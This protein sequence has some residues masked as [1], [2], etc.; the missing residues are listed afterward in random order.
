[1]LKS[2]EFIENL[3]KELKIKKA[4]GE[5]NN[6]FIEMR[7][8]GL[9]NIYVV[10]DEINELKKLNL[11]SFEPDYFSDKKIKFHYLSIEDSKDDLFISK[12][13]GKS[14]FLGLRRSL[15][16]L[17]DLNEEEKLAS[18]RNLITFY[19]YKGGVG[20]TTSLALTASYLAKQ[21]KNV[22]VVD[23][24]FEAPGLLN[25]FN[26]SQSENNRSGL[27]E[28]LNDQTFSTKTELKDYVFGIESAYSGEG[29]INLISAG[30]ILFDFKNV[31]SYLEGIAKIDLQ[32]DSLQYILSKL[33]DDINNN[34]SPDVILVDSR[35]GFN[36]VF[37]ALASI[38]TH[39]VFLGGDDIQNQPGVEYTSNIINKNKISSSIILSIINSNFSKRFENFNKYISSLFEQEDKPDTFY[40]NRLDVLEKIGTESEDPSDLN[41]FLNGDI[42]PAQY[43]R[44]FKTIDDVV[45]SFKKGIESDFNITDGNET[46]L[47]IVSPTEVEVQTEAEVYS[48]I[49]SSPSQ[50]LIDDLKLQDLILEKVNSKLPNLYA[51]NIPYTPEY[52]ERDFYLRPCMEDFLIPEKNIL[53]GDKGTGKTAFYKA[54]Q[55]KSFFENLITKSQKKH[56]NYDVINIT[57]F[58]KDNFEFLFTQDEFKDEIFVKKFWLFFIWNSLFTRGGFKTENNNLL[59]SLEAPTA[60]GKIFNIIKN[61]SNIELIENDLNQANVILRKGDRRLIITFDQLDNIVKPVIWDFVI[62]PLVK[63]AVRF[64]YSNINPKLFLRRDLYDRL[65]NLTN[66]N[67]FS[68]KTINLEWSQDE[69]F[70]FFL[71]IV[72]NYARNEFLAFLGEDRISPY[73]LELITKKLT[74]KS[75]L[76]NQLPLDSGVIEPV[77]NSFFGY[78][79]PKNNGT[80]STAYIDLYRNIQSA[81]KTVNLRPFIDLLINAIDEQKE[82]DQNKGFR[83]DAIIGLAYCTSKSVRK[84]AVLNYLG[85]LW[86]EQGNEFIKYFCADFSQ[87]KISPMF[88]RNW[89]DESSFDKLI[90]EIKENNK[91]D[92]SI[93]GST[94]EQLK[95]VL[96]ATKIITTYMVGNKNRYSI[97]YL[98]TNY[99]GL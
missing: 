7:V 25:F 18:K 21:G 66:K 56:L 35:T 5:I 86:N 64:P 81:D 32:G 72:F 67:A 19:S 93:S 89:L 4:K 70:S 6:F 94:V 34:Y 1:M 2:I 46:P 49:H 40:F 24:D 88:K 84:N 30:N 37:G 62:S 92:E 60:I 79:R 87:N 51:E 53:L 69:I 38:S 41:D 48:P 65:G 13:E 73:L 31:V 68:N 77:I 61:D 74:V 43:H 11:S 16:S 28:Y 23:C 36:N 90:L 14:Y 33:I 95:Q 17:L 27:V 71:K 59:V 99:L 85:D 47:S 29:S 97:A 10:S 83:K 44:F 9:I 54:L 80:M 50:I 52:M 42:G 75:K 82:Q 12:F 57:N 20:R 76:H 45:C 15:K 63:L 26:S 96:I 58:N 8:N 91:E 78:P 22:F 55:I 39:I 3:D 98:Y